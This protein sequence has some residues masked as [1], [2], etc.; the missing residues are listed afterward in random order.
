[1][2]TLQFIGGAHEVTGS[3]HLLSTSSARILLDCGMFQG[4]A[5]AEAKNRRRFPFDPRKI[6]AV[7]LSH[8]HLDHS[9]L[10]PRLVKSGFNGTIHATP[11]TRD[12]LELLL[13]DAAFL[14][15]KDIE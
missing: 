7:V 2:A 13:K 6:D 1:M 4:S 3:C 9:G 5:G 14:E 10:L 8:A 15:E 12:L 11:A